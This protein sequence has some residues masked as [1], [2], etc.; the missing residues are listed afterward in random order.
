MKI[1]WN[2]RWTRLEH[3]GSGGRPYPVV[4]SSRMRNLV[5]AEDGVTCI[6]VCTPEGSPVE[7]FS[8]SME[9]GGE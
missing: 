7:E 1:L 4:S 6:S 5:P 2:A 3:G 8:L 9:R